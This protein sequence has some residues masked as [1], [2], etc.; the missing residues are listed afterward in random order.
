MQNAKFK[1]FNNANG[2]GWDEI[3]I[4][5]SGGRERRKKYRADPAE[6]E[7][8]EEPTNTAEAE[9][10]DAEPT[11]EKQIATVAKKRGRP[12]KKG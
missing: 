5:S 3:Q 1:E 8:V 7:N 6:S 10:A 11:S 12:S 9:A 2:S 4:I